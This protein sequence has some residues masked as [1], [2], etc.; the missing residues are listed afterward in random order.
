MHIFKYVAWYVYYDGVVWGI[1]ISAKVSMHA[2]LLMGLMHG[3]QISFIALFNMVIFAFT[4]SF[5]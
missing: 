5:L 4:L 3:C 1:M 2:E